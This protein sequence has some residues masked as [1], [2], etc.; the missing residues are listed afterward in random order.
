MGAPSSTYPFLMRVSHAVRNES[1]QEIPALKILHLVESFLARRALCSIE[2][3]GLHAVFKRLWEDS[4][5]VVTADTV[6]AAMKK[7]K[8]VKWPSDVII[9]VETQPMYKSAICAFVV[10]EYDRSLGG[11]SVGV[12][13]WIEHVLPEGWTAKQ[14]PDVAKDEHLELKDVLGNL[15]PLTSEMNKTL[16]NS[17]YAKKRPVYM[18]DSAFKSARLLG[19]EYE[20]WSSD[21]IRARSALIAGW[22][23][24]RWED[25]SL[26]Q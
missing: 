13:P 16:S 21:E 4:G 17:A 18:A 8:T 19:E 12:D 10:L 11:D 15:I 2:P 26:T 6:K 25:T 14:W 20:S 9:A 1:L 5:D 23:V 22:S 3:T 24:L 7:H